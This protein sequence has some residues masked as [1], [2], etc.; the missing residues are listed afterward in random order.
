M[1]T[2]PGLVDHPVE[3]TMVDEF[4]GKTRKVEQ[5]GTTAYLKDAPRGAKDAIQQ[6]VHPGM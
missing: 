5:M 4:A 2:P 6:M 3:T 1:S